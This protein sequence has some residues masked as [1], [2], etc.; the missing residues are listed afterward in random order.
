MSL[1]IEYVIIWQTV[2]L[3][4]VWV[5]IVDSQTRARSAF[6]MWNK[7]CGKNVCG[8]GGEARVVVQCGILL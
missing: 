6:R 4:G 1:P 5:A 8:V 7:F 3:S 2:D